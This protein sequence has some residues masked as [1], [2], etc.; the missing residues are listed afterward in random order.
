MCASLAGTAQEI[1]FLHLTV[2]E[3]I[4][5]WHIFKCVHKERISKKK[6]S[7][8]LHS[9]VF[10]GFWCRQIPCERPCL[11][12]THMREGNRR[13]VQGSDLVLCVSCSEWSMRDILDCRACS[14]SALQ[15]SW[16]LCKERSLPHSISYHHL[17]R[18]LGCF[19]ISLWVSS[20]ADKNTWNNREFYP[21][22]LFKAYSS[23]DG[24]V[25]QPDLVL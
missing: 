2:H 7:V 16:V 4:T 20:S 1:L 24:F 5:P 10:H 8:H 19:S 21:R 11:V 6:G 23:S 18:L 13:E 17:A 9:V 22:V 12:Q 25:W 3:G 15:V 14:T